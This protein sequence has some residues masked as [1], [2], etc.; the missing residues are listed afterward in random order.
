MIKRN[1]KNVNWQK[2]WK[3]LK[4]IMNKLSLAKTAKSALEIERIK[5]HMEEQMR[6]ERAEATRTSETS[7]TIHN[8][9]VTLAQVNM[10]KTQKQ[11]RSRKKHY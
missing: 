10:K 8:V 3:E 1:K 7:A 9:R 11:E 5:K 4:P 2:N 6:K